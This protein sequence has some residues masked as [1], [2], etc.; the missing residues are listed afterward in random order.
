MYMSACHLT[1]YHELYR[2]FQL[3][4]L[5]YMAFASHVPE[6]MASK[7]P[8]RRPTELPPEVHVP[9]QHMAW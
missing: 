4:A 9:M 2:A 6:C 3:N 7:L 8:G 5:H 1:G